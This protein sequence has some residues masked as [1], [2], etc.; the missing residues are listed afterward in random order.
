MACAVCAQLMLDDFDMSPV[1]ALSSV[2][3]ALVICYLQETRPLRNWRKLDKCKK[4]IQHSSEGGV[5]FGVAVN[6]E[7][8]PPSCDR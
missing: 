5:Y 3:C 2:L 4:V 1:Y 8:R 7:L 6:S